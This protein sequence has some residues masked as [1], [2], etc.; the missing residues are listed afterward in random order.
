MT[1]L[2]GVPDHSSEDA[3]SKP[4]GFLSHYRSAIKQVEMDLVGL[5]VKTMRGHQYILVIVDYATRYPEVILLRTVTGERY[6]MGALPL[7]QPGGY[8]RGNPDGP[9]HCIHVL[10]NERCLQSFTNQTSEDQCEPST[11]GRA[12]KTLQEDPK[13]D[14][15]EGNRERWEKLGPAAAP[16]DV[17][18]AG[19]TPSIHWVLPL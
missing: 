19:G 15:E 13:A 2:P 5:L 8:S 9:W 12:S 11:N 6:R 10:C 17:F 4:F 14:A 1:Y 18:I 3:L 16:P 7:I